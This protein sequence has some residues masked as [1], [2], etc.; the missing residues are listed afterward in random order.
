MY[1]TCIYCNRN[2]GS[3]EIVENF[4]VGRR[5]AFDQEKG[6]LWVVCERCRRWNLSPLEER[7]EAIEE[8]E[9]QF[10]D[11]SESFST[12]NIGLARTG[13][14][15]ELVRIGRPLRREFAAWRYGKQFL[16]RRIKSLV[17]WAARIGGSVAL[18][19]AGVYVVHLFAEQQDRIVARVRA[20]NGQRL[21]IPLK[22]ARRA[23]LLRSAGAADGWALSLAYRERERNWGVLGAWSK[24][25]RKFIEL[26]GPVAL[27]AAGRIM[28][29]LNRFGG[30]NSQVQDA[31]NLI[32]DARGPE[33]FF[34]AAARAPGKEMGSNPFVPVERSRVSRMDATVRLALEMAA[35]EETERRVFEGELA[36]LEEAWR[37]A[38]EIAAI[39][40]RLLIPESVESWIRKQK[41]RLAASNK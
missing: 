31:V 15:L 20:E 6:R 14:G 39:A 30:S 27:R 35:H 28:P 1:K 36:L 33:R 25:K 9:R 22:D 40:D 34:H 19:F 21:F 11:T 2:L 26:A 12:D 4:P 3:N 32:E 8:C 5:L 17:G 37:E 23:R 7:W 24:G 18:A 16:K 41:A 13:E 29:A 10:R 38:E